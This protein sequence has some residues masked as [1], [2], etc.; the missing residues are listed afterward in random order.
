M[1][2][3][4]NLE[5]ALRLAEALIKDDPDTFDSSAAHGAISDGQR[6]AELVTALD[7]WI[8]KG[9]FLPKVWAEEQTLELPVPVALAGTLVMALADA[10]VVTVRSRRDGPDVILTLKKVVG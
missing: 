3:D 9:G 1:D 2:P 7:G 6:L 5:E 8:R 4:A 10:G